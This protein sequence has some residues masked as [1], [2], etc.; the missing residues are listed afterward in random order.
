MKKV[1][2]SVLVAVLVSACGSTEKADPTIS[3]SA[4]KL[5][6]EGKSEL[7]D[8]NY[9]K[10]VELFEKLEA[11]YPYGR[12]AQQSQLYAAYA[13]YKDGEPEAAVAACDRFIKLHPTH[14]NVDYAYYLKGLA[15]FTEDTS[16]FGQVA[17]QDMTERDPKAARD[18]FEAFKQLVTL[19]P[20]SKYTPDAVGRMRYL[21]DALASHEVHV[22]EYYMKRS[23]YVAAANRAKYALEHYP[24]AP[25]VEEALVV[26]YGAYDKLGMTDLR[27]DAKRVLDK[28]YPN[29]KYLT[30]EVQKDKPWWQLW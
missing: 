21:V 15:N 19:F 24:Q 11:R 1:L 16:L 30:G 13:N 2:S 20:N 18:S 23:A 8:K 10:A 28:N 6:S 4:Q 25:A 9:T 7:D 12:F 26:M 3:W 5:Y 14:P 27:D 22:A 29:S 17:N